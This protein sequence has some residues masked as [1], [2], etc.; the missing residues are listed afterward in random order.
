MEKRDPKKKKNYQTAAPGQ[1]TTFIRPYFVTWCRCPRGG[2]K[3]LYGETTKRMGTPR[4]RNFIPEL[5]DDEGK[6]MGKVG[7]SWD[8]VMPRK[9]CSVRIYSMK[10]VGILYVYIH[11]KKSPCVIAGID[12]SRRT[13]ADIFHP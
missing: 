3:L 1:G 2:A 6:E 4:E 5:V 13:D 9:R 7:M 10:T 8:C 11:R 12:F